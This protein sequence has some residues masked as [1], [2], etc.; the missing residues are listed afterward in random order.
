MKML[1]LG[2]VSPSNASREFFAAKDMG[3][4]FSDT[5]DIYKNRDFIFANLECALT[6]SESPIVKIGR[7]LKAPIETAEVL[8]DIGV[9]L[10]GLSNNHIFDFGKRG[11]ADTLTALD[12]AGIAYTGFGDNYEDSRK[13][14][15][16]E[17][18]G[19]KF[20]IIAVSEHEY[21]YA[22]DDRMGA[23]PFDEI[24]TL[25]DIRAAREKGARV[26]VIYHGG[27]EFCRYPSPRHRKVCQGMVRA[28]AELIISQHSHCVGCFEEYNGATIVYGQGNFHFVLHQSNYCPDMDMWSSE[29]AIEYDTETKKLGYIPIRA[30]NPG[31]IKLAEDGKEILEGFYERSKT[32]LNKEEWLKEW[33]SFCYGYANPAKYI[34]A[35]DNATKDEEVRVGEDRL[36]SHY[37]DCEAHVDVWRE[38]FPSANQTN[39][40]D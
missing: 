32:L 29:L 40:K 31:G 39:D 11:I 15:V 37:L 36:F 27:K 8:A 28:G 19:E 3:A 10:C 21:A 22:L 12:K 30:T 14:Y 33:H 18:D 1:F 35:I 38:M 9:N 34:W 2:D 25:E 23:R 7:P 26:I 13:D 16:F 6:E 5:L 24:H 17:K 20:A 4:L